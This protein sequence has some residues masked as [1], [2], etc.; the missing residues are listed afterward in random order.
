[1]PWVSYYTDQW[2]NM[3]EADKQNNV[4]IIWNY[5]G[6]Q[7]GYSAEAVSA[8]C[9]NM[10]YEGL[11]NPQQFEIGRNYDIYNYGA[12]LCG[13]TPVY[14]SDNPRQHLGNWADENGLNWM[15]GDT[16]LYYIEYEL[17]DWNNT[18]RFFRN[19]LAPEFGQP[20]NPPIT[21]NDFRTSTINPATLSAYWQLYYEHPANPKATY[22]QRINA[23]NKWYE[24]ITGITPPEPVPIPVFWKRKRGMPVWLMFC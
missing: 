22:Q 3:T 10:E 23:T 6:G 9:G 21:A 20:Y 13:W 12:G 17:T 2:P 4:D 18:E 7:L 1:M 8:I 15:D 5:L 19:P 14:R 24:Y 16:Q 11:L